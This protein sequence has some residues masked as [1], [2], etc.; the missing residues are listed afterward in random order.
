MK[1]FLETFFSLDGKNLSLVGASEK[2][3]KKSS[4]LARKSVVL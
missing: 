2:Y 1:N 3:R 4:L